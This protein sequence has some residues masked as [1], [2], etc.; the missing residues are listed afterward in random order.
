[1]TL[2][3]CTGREKRCQ[4]RCTD[5]PTKQLCIE[6]CTKYFRCNRPGGPQSRLQVMDPDMTPEYDAPTSNATVSASLS[7]YYNNILLLSFLV[8]S[9]TTTVILL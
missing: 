3:E 6:G 2:S 1:M 7:H 9:F 5:Q 8:A 4:A